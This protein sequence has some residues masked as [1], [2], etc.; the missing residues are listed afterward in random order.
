M[1]YVEVSCTRA[2]LPV[3]ISIKCFVLFTANCHTK[4]IQNSRITVP[5]EACNLVE[6]LI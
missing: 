6:L 1:C 4:S 5:E 3:K 2:L